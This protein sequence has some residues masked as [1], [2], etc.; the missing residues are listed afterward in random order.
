MKNLKKVF[1]LVL[2]LAMIVS[3]F[4]VS[5][6]A[7]DTKTDADICEA[8]EL[9]KGDGDGVTEEYLGTE[10]PRWKLALMSLRLRGLEDEALAF[11]GTE[12]FADAEKMT[13]VAGRAALA[14]LKANPELGWLGRG[15]EF[16][17][18]GMMTVQEYYK[19][20]LGTLGYTQGED[21]EWEDVMTFAE[22][23]NLVAAADAEKLTMADVA[24]VTVE[25]LKA[26]NSEGIIL[27]DALVEAGAIDQDLAVELDLVDPPVVAVLESVVSIDNNRVHANYDIELA[28]APEVT[29]VDSKDKEV[30]VKEVEVKGKA[31]VIDTADMIPGTTY[32]VTVGDVTKTIVAKPA[33]TTKPAVHST[34]PVTSELVRV[35]FNSTD[36]DL[37]TIVEEDFTINNDLLSTGVVVDEAYNKNN[38]GKTA[39]LLSTSPQKAGKLYTITINNVAD[40]AGNLIKASTTVKFAGKAV[41][42]T[43]PAIKSVVS[44]D[45]NTISIKFTESSRLNEDTALDVSNYTVEGLTITNATLVKGSN[46]Y[47]AD[48][49]VILDTDTQKAGKLYTLSIGTGLLDE[50]GNAPKQTLTKKFAG[51][52]L[53]TTKL[54]FV[55]VLATN[56]DKVK[57]TFNDKTDE[58]ALDIANYSIDNDLSVVEAEYLVKTDGTNDTSVVYLTTSEQ[59]QGKLYS[60]TVTNVLDD[61]GNGFASTNT[62]KFAGV[63]KDTTP[64]T[65][66]IRS[67]NSGTVVVQFSE[68]LDADT[69]SNVLNYTFNND[70]G[71]ATSAV[72]DKATN[73]VT[74][75]TAAQTAGKM[76]TVTIDGV[77]DVNG[78]IATGSKKIEKTFAGTAS[79]TKLQVSSAVSV[80]RHTFKIMFNQPVNGLA[81]TD[82]IIINESQSS[83]QSN[84]I[85]ANHSGTSTPAVL[86]GTVAV[87]LNTEK[88]EAT[89]TFDT[90]R[91]MRASDLYKVKVQNIAGKFG[92]VLDTDNNT[93]YFGG[94]ATEKKVSV[95]T[96]EVIDSK[97]IKLVFNCNLATV[98]T[99]DTGDIKITLDGTTTPLDDSNTVSVN[100]NKL[101]VKLASGQFEANKVYNIEFND[102]NHQIRDVS[103]YFDVSNEDGSDAVFATSNLPEVKLAADT[104]TQKD[105]NLIDVYF[106]Y[107]VNITNG[108]TAAAAIQILKDDASTPVS[109]TVSKLVVDTNDKKLVHVYTNKDLSG[110]ASNVYYVDF[111]ATNAATNVQ[112]ENDAAILLSGNSSTDAK[113][114]TFAKSIADD[115]TPEIESVVPV[116]SETIEVTFKEGLKAVANTNVTD[117]DFVIKDAAGKT[118]TVEIQAADQVAIDTADV[119]TYFKKLYFSIVD[120]GTFAQGKNYT[121]NTASIAGITD[122]EGNPLVAPSSAIEFTG[123]DTGDTNVVTATAFAANITF[124]DGNHGFDIA[125]TAATVFNNE[126]VKVQIAVVANDATASD[127]VVDYESDYITSYTGGP[128]DVYDGDIS[129]LTQ[130]THDAYVR[131]VDTAGNASAWVEVQAD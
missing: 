74:L 10:S 7:E 95:D 116:D 80:D 24:A 96:V 107:P 77:M 127:D 81:N 39:V 41:D 17:P 35:V 40:K 123:L 52:P 43:G 97:N 83:A 89:V 90:N 21:F 57:V 84:D 114:V 82:L 15:E 56:N 115:D 8:L 20:M 117:G 4:T 67:A 88:T 18:N 53:D 72:Y 42:K 79:S 109:L 3:T 118:I 59:V 120:G 5:F 102:T 119:D 47:T 99:L 26:E 69:A 33:D 111:T 76:Y 103:T 49:E 106:N 34:L 66:T 19:V 44:K 46:E 86:N 50:F 1:A 38:A 51:T 36:L 113:K 61:A 28:V 37:A 45:G 2:S 14:Y 30:E 65:A 12:T 85:T 73:R 94:I 11:E 112:Y 126:L 122:L 62:K 104:A 64:P 31:V 92:A 105:S 54:G 48:P 93:A 63:K 55:A 16:D 22:E 78:N 23:K 110:S 13:W 75:T 68:D 121:F 32:T 9:I 108:A 58:S 98:T 128:T 91:Y 27:A 70:L 6:A 101:S 87:T 71:Y 124:D 131:L 125:D 29:I 60:L 129:T 100:D 25:V 130:G